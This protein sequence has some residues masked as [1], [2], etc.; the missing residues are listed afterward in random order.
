MKNYFLFRYYYT[1][2]LTD[3]GDYDYVDIYPERFEQFL[4]EVTAN[5]IDVMEALLQFVGYCLSNDDIWEQKA[6]YLYGNTN[7]GKST[8]INILRML[9]GTSGFSSVR[10]K[11]LNEPEDRARLDGKLFNIADE[12]RSRDFSD[13]SS[14]KIL[15]AGDF[16]TI[17]I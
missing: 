12:T 7:N 10:L 1:K 13:M 9:V 16:F 14:F 8:F 17:Y 6:L 15:T 3:T 2:F 11:D 4:G 5:D